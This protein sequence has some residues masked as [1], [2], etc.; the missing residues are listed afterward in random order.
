MAINARQ[1]KQHTFNIDHYSESDDQRYS[2][3]FTCQKLALRDFGA[4]GVRKSQLNG[5]YYYSEQS[6]GQGIDKFTDDL[7]DIIA[8][9]EL[10]LVD[11]PDWW[12]LD[13]V[14]DMELLG[15][16]YGEVMQFQNSFRGR[17]RPDATEGSDSGGSSQGS[18]EA[19]K[20]QADT[21]GSPA[22]VVGSEVQAALEP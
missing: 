12:D 2:G 17:N 16:V 15:K 8:H 7:N 18:G 11:T 19:D 22:E 10:A 9:L 6:P 5:G 21:S 3:T 13:V 1:K 4:L 14:G 20:A